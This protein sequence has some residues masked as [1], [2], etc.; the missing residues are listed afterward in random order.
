MI[1]IKKEDKK[2]SNWCD[3]I[4]SIATDA[5]VDDDLIKPENFDKA[6]AVISEEIYIRV[7]CLN[8]FP[9]QKSN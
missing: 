6:V 1:Q 8:D 4:A 9:P 5:L 3:S 2:I 7:F